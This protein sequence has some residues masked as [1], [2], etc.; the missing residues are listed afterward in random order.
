MSQFKHAVLPTRLGWIGVVASTRG[1]QRLNLPVKSAGEALKR[2]GV[3]FT[4][5]SPD[6][7]F[8]V[9]IHMYLKRYF[10]GRT[11]DFNYALDI[12]PGVSFFQQ[13]WRACASIP[14]G[15]TRTYKWLAAQAGN[16]R[17]VRA[18][19]QA[20][21]HNPVSIIIPCHRVVANNGSLGGY[22]GGLALKQWLLDLERNSSQ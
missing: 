18:A 14:S 5:V 3:D 17:A 20:M 2:L 11:V 15:E 22:G 6:P 8:F 19:G 21:A 10:S 16:P 12:G 7:S 1:L 9:G 13:A 4:G